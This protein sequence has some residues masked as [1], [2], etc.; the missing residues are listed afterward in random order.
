M[1]TKTELKGMIIK[2]NINSQYLPFT[3]LKVNANAA[4]YGFV[5]SYQLVLLVQ[6]NLI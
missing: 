5:I 6:N 1:E 3:Q 2:S 4:P